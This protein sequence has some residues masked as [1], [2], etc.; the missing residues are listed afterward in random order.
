MPGCSS[1]V[2]GV[3]DA[4]RSG[5]AA[6]RR[7]RGRR[8]AWPGE[9]VRLGVWESS[10]FSDVAR[11]HVE[12]VEDAP[13]T[14]VTRTTQSTRGRRRRRSARRSPP[15]TPG[16]DRWKKRR[17]RGRRITARLAHCGGTA[18]EHP[19]R[20]ARGEIGEVG[21]PAVRIVSAAG[22]LHAGEVAQQVVQQEALPLRSDEDRVGTLAHRFEAGNLDHVVQGGVI[23]SGKVLNS[24]TPTP[25]YPGRTRTSFSFVIT[26]G[27]ALPSGKTKRAARWG[28]P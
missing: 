9:G 3:V 8:R 23:L 12:P 13:A 16:T 14:R 28:R 25:Q 4:R 27:F 21:H 1:R 7:P 6:S 11:D 10:A 20:S 26:L 5:T 22:G 15:A 17:V 24:T 2:S 18:D 19:P